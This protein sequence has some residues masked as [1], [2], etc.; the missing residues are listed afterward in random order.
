MICL[1]KI[2]HGWSTW[3]LTK[4]EFE[5]IMQDYISE[6]TF[7]TGLIFHGYFNTFSRG[8]KYYVNIISRFNKTVFSITLHSDCLIFNYFNP[9]IQKAILR[10]GDKLHDFLE[11]ETKDI[12]K[13][14]ERQCGFHV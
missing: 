8:S 5:Q 14:I 10:T 2:I 1:G 12:I 3:K 9:N 13:H 11:N 7:I 4:N 6:L